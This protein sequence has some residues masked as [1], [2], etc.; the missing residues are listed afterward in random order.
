MKRRL[1]LFALIL[2]LVGGS[3]F[4]P[5]PAGAITYGFIDSTNTFANTGAF[6]AR[7]PNGEIFPICSGTLLTSNVF[8]TA[9][10]CTV[11]FTDEWAPEGFTA[12]VSLDGLIPF[13]GLSTNTTQLLPVAHVVTNPNYNQSQSDS[14]DIGVLIL[15]NHVTGVTPVQLPTCELLDQ[16]AAKNGLKSAVFTAVGYGVQNRVTGGGVPFFQDLNPIPRMF[17]FSSFN[18]LNGGYLRLSQNPS[19]GNGGTCFGDSGG[20]NFMTVNGQQVQVGITITGDSVCRSTNVTYRLDIP[21]AQAF[22]ASVNMAF[23]TSIPL[24]C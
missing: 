23:G 2:T 16:L 12:F 24:S 5:R 9:S 14:G 10:H 18:S 8:L 17:A 22:L 4:L 6:I 21:S 19:T 20:P 3:L 11:A 13:G 15:Q 1:C 7:S